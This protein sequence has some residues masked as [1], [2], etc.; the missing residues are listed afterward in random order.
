MSYGH[1]GFQVKQYKPWKI[2][3]G[4]VIVLL[5]FYVSFL[6][7]QEY[8]AYELNHLLLERETLLSQIAHLETRNSSLVK[9]NAQLAGDS[10]IEHDAYQQANRTL[11]DNQR[12]I[13]KLKEELVFY[14]GIVSPSSAALGV[15]L[16]SFQVTQKNPRNFYSYKLVLTKNGKSTRKIQGKFDVIIRGEDKG[17][18]T[19]LKLVDLKA[20]K[21][22][23]VESFA[24]RYFE[25]FV[26]EIVLP[27]TFIPYEVEIHINPSTKKVESVTETFSWAR[28][29]SE[30]L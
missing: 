13:L 2:W 5:L 27:K 20:E 12:E 16:Q 17:K 25:T 19:E 26:G 23:K 15:N 1:R 29:V 28:V 9:K 30:G 6:F 21:K 4:A 3:L 7:G 11:V 10:K 18:S 8:Q 22:N 14:Q 24:F